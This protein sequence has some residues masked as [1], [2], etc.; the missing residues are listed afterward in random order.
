MDAVLMQSTYLAIMFSMAWTGHAI[1][2]FFLWWLPIFLAEFHLNYYLAWKPH[3]PGVEQGR[4]RDTRAFKSRF[5][6]IISAG[7]QYHIIHHL[8]P[9]TP[10]SLT[11]AAYR[12]LKPILEQRGCELGALQ[13]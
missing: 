9:R 5:G 4:Y 2:A 11:P 7:M 10:L 3:H 6:N 1:E 8:Y 13:H 12:E